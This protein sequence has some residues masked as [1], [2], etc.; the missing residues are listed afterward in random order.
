MAQ[1]T[2]DTPAGVGVVQMPVSLEKGIAE[3][4]KAKILRTPYCRKMLLR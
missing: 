4:T 2:L 3:G 1:Q